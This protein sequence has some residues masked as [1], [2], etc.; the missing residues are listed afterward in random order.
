VIEGKGLGDKKVNRVGVS[1]SNEYLTKL[2]RLSTAC[3]MKPT[4]LAGLLLERCL[5]DPIIVAA[6]Q[7]EFC[8]HTAYKVLPIK[9]YSTGKVEYQLNNQERND[10]L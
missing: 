8:L 10:Y 9:D 2:N 4:T 7:K 1:L 3:H 6:L 5:D